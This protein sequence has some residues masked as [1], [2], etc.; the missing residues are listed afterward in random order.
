MCVTVPDFF[1]ILKFLEH[2]QKRSHKQHSSVSSTSSAG[3]HSTSVSGGH[4]SIPEGGV[5][6]TASDGATGY[7]PSAPLPALPEITLETSSDRHRSQYSRSH[8]PQSMSHDSHMIPE[9]EEDGGG[10]NRVVEMNEIDEEVKR[11]ARR[12]K[13]RCRLLSCNVTSSPN[14]SIWG[15][16]SEDGTAPSGNGLGTRLNSFDV[17][18]RSSNDSGWE[19]FLQPY[20]V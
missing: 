17:R 4:G 10:A 9:E 1:P 18:R 3:P 5:Q 11:L 20:S 16:S 7:P 6:Y 19:H 12:C 15:G 14:K 13:D 8:D 2:S